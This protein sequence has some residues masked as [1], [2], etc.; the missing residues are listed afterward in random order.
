MYQHAPWH[1]QI[2]QDQPLTPINEGYNRWRPCLKDAATTA[3]VILA[4]SD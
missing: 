1:T 2:G 3:A 4:I